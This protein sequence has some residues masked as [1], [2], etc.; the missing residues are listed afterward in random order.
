MCGIAGITTVNTNQTIQI[1]S[2]IG[3]ASFLQHRGPDE[4]GIYRSQSCG[5]VSTRLSIVDLAGGQQPIHNEDQTLWI[6]FNGEIFNY[7]ELKQDLVKKDHRFLTNTDTE[8]ILHLYEEYGVSALQKLNGQFAFAIWDETKQSLF[9]ARDRFGI[10]PLFY[11]LINNRLLFASEIKAFLALEDWQPELDLD[12]IQQVFTYWAALSPASVFKGI[13]ELPPAHYMIF[14]NGSLSTHPYWQMD[15]TK[16]EHPLTD[17]EYLEQFE[18]LLIQATQI[19]LRA[20]VEVGA[21]LSGGLDSSTTTAIIQNHSDTPVETFSI[22]FAHPA[23]DEREFQME[24]TKTLGV[25][26]HEITCN[27]EDIGRIFPEVIWHTEIPILRTSPAPMYLLSKLVHENNYKVV[28]TGEG[29][30]EILGGYDIFKEDKIR[31]FVARQPESQRRAA[32]FGVLYPEIANLNQAKFV[33][34]FFGKNITD[35]QADFYT[36]HIRWFN[37]SRTNRF[38]NQPNNL[39]YTPYNYPIDLPAEFKQWSSLAQTQYLEIQ[40]FMSPY[41]L[42]SQ[43]DRM[44]MANSIEGRYPFLDVNLV[45]F[46][47]NLPDHL[48]LRGLQEKWILRHFAKKMLPKE[49]WLRRK[50]PYRAP[51]IDSFINNDPD[52][53]YVMDLLSTDGLNKNQ[54]FNPFGVGK[55]LSK[56]NN[57]GKLSEIEEMAL[58]GMIS[59]QLLDQFFIQKKFSKPNP[60]PREKLLIIDRIS[61]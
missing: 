7:I 37:T 16:P 50:K 3:M 46:A 54:I 23:Y 19:R 56:A 31:R 58:T 29:A 42:S 28:L 25:N 27:A 39:S 45:E 43:G 20:D 51:I 11:Q 22:Q 41:L 52:S 36:H 8:V 33:Q 26:H 44:A 61:Q 35:T 6:V 17:Q 40:T 48:K 13:Q 53:A 57:A 21:Y 18:S 9:V 2:L 60:I 10:R 5:L 34:S 14:K 38:L 49:I 47:N 32:L 12:A 59:T 4:Y 55:L 15:F 30:D 24:F 1:D